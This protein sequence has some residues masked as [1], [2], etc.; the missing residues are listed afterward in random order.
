ML[1]LLPGEAPEP[2]EG[3]GQD[4]LS[5]LRLNPNRL[6]LPSA[7]LISAVSG[8][9]LSLS[10]PPAG[11]WPI[12]WLAP[13]PLLWLVRES[14]PGRAA[15]CGF[16]F[17]IAYFGALLYWILLFGELGWAALVLVSG[18]FM[19]AFGALAP[20]VWRRGHPILGTFGLAALWTVVEWFRSMVPVGGFTWGQLGVTQVDAPALPLAS[21]GGVWALSFTVLLAAGFLLLA[22]ERWGSGRRARAA[23]LLVAAVG[24]AIAPAAIPI[25]QPDGRTIDVAAIQVDVASVQ[26]LA[27]VEEDVAVAQLNVDRHLQLAED[28]PDLVV[29][30]EGALDPGV[31]GDPAVMAQIRQAIAAVGAPTIAGAV[32]EDPDGSEHT[33]TL[34]FD[35]TGRIVDRYD[36]VKLVPFGE[37]VPFRRE[38][39]WISATDQ[40]PVDRTPGTDVRPVSIPGLPVIGTPICYENSFPAIPREMVADGAGFL[41]VV[42]NN[43]SYGHTAASE[44]HLQMSRLRAVENGRWLVHAAVSGISAFIDPDGRVMDSRGLFEPSTMRAE[45][46]ASDRETPYTR[47]GDWVPWGSLVL[48]FGLFALPRGRR[49]PER[50]PGPLPE[51]PRALVILPT[52]NERATI[53]RVLDGVGSVDADLHVLVVDDGSPDGTGALVRGRTETDPRIALIERPRKSGL[54]SAYAVGFAKAIAEGYDLAVEMDSDLSHRPEE[55]PRLLEAAREHH[56]VI[57]SRYVP[58][59]SVTNW[60][61]AR[62]AL[63]KAGNLYARLWLGFGVHDATSGFRVYRTDALREI[64]ATPISSDGYGFQI[65]LVYRAWNLGLSVGE[66]PISFREREHGQSK[67]SRR[68]VVEAL[69]LVTVWGMRARFRPVP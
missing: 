25:P 66:A 6:R 58:G 59:G 33:S 36:K 56:M 26:D 14:R 41:V 54:A 38:L 47:F 27:G 62:L 31:T 64:T 35:G 67:I 44:Q 55:L 9:L 4:A 60:S 51:R 20:A 29:W 22:L 52:Y 5:R 65:E 8:A 2:I 39:G 28:P 68:I 69:W 32:I 23:W 40:V 1:E 17:G 57:G 21:I 19:A 3:Q 61:R 13:I 48:V 30:G 18:A 50:E 34:A 16:V 63:S 37:Y 43:A 53:E 10:L 49:R 45:I 24:V 12:V 7:L 42:I 46:R 11:V 15:L